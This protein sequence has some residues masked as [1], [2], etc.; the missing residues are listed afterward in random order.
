MAEHNHIL[1]NPC[2]P[3]PF[4]CSGPD[5]SRLPF[6]KN[7]S[8]DNVF[9]ILNGNRRDAAPAGPPA[10]IC[11]FPAF[12]ICAALNR[13]HF[14]LRL[15]RSGN[16]PASWNHPFGAVE[17]PGAGLTSMKIVPGIKAP[18]AD[19]QDREFMIYPLK[20][21]DPQVFERR[22]FGGRH[23]R[24]RFKTGTPRNTPRPGFP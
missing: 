7:G 20:A 11:G 22:P 21:P 10:H 12:G 24:P 16:R 4:Q 3:L 8:Q 9:A 19:E 6:R 17:M 2:P 13:P 23:F 15:P 14:D 18:F 5:T 1:L